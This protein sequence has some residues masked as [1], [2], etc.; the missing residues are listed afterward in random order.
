MK[1]LL[2]KYKLDDV[3]YASTS[4]ALSTNLDFDPNGEAIS[5]EVYIGKIGSLLHLTSKPHI[6]FSVCLCAR[7]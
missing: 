2:T 3:K 4:M 7:F 5:E 6:M 1:E